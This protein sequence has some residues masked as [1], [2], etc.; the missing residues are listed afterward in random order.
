MQVL[1]RRFDKGNV[2]WIAASTHP[3]LG[4]PAGHTLHNHM[5]W[6]SLH[7]LSCTDVGLS[8][9]VWLQRVEGQPREDAAFAG[10]MYSLP[11]G[12]IQGL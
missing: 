12:A 6:P 4:T 5:G 11:S 10:I 7:C 2:A 1:R 3:P 8:M 9:D